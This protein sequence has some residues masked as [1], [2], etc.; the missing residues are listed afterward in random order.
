MEVAA[1]IGLP[2]SALVR[3]V[4]LPSALPNFLTGLRYAIGIA[5]LSLVVRALERTA[6]AWPAGPRG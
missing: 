4:I 6:L 5:W 2:R 1:T 3:H